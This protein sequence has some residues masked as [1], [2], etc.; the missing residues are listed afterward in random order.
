MEDF[1]LHYRENNSVKKIADRLNY[2]F[3]GKRPIVVCI[4]TDLTIGDSLGPIVGTMLTER[5]LNAF[6][7]GTLTTPITAKDVVSM[8]R[9]LTCAHPMSR[10]LV[11]DAAIGKKEDLGYIKTCHAPIKPGLGADKNLPEIGNVNII[12]IVAEKSSANYSFLNLTRLS[13]VY[14]MSK[15]IA[16]GITGYFNETAA[17]NRISAFG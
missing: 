2:Y 15:I 8:R 13:K 6:I 4:G 3:G 14:E 11:I 5:K 9:F 16:D 7:Y 10:I 17:K 1:S 12:G